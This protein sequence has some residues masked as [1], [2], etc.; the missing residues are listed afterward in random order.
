MRCSGSG[1]LQVSQEQFDKILG[2][3]NKGVEEGAK[4]EVGGKRYGVCHPHTCSESFALSCNPLMP[5]SMTELTCCSLPPYG[6]QTPAW[7]LYFSWSTEDSVCIAGD[8][9]YF[10]QPTVFSNVTDEMTIA[11]EEIFGPVQS[12]L[13]W[14]T[15]EEVSLPS[16]T[17]CSQTPSMLLQGLCHILHVS[18]NFVEYFVGVCSP[19]VVLCFVEQQTTLDMHLSRSSFNNFSSP[20][21]NAWG[22]SNHVSLFFR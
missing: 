5:I 13:K 9:G 18:F 14:S 7:L 10:V 15:V 6:F 2:L 4:V 12:I 8:K 16:Q 22:G 17:D 21:H 3:I 19:H 11:K 20:G 1:C